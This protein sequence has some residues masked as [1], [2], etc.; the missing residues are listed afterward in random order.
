MGY[1]GWSEND[2]FIFL[3]LSPSG[4]VAAAIDIKSPDLTDA[5]IGYWA[6]ESHPGCMTNTTTELLKL[7]RVAGFRSLFGRTKKGNIDSVGVLLRAG[8][9]FDAV[10]SEESD[11]Y[12]FYRIELK[13]NGDENKSIDDNG[14]G[15]ANPRVIFTL[16]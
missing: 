15:F 4:N 13:E 11:T 12:D 2:K 5:E 6:S 14:Y 7:A 10:D 3:I 16:I 9:R 8:F 1:S